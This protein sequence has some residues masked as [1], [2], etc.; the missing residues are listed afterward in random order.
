M[1]RLEGRFYVAYCRR[2]ILVALQSAWKDASTLRYKAAGR[3]LLRCVTKRLEGRF[4]VALQSAWKDAS[5]LR[6]KAA[7][8]T[9]LRCVTKRLEGRFY[10]ALQSGWKVASTLR[11]KAP[12]RSLL[13]CVTKRLGS[14]FY[15]NV[16]ATSLSRC[17]ANLLFGITSFAVASIHHT[18]FAALGRLRRR[19]VARVYCGQASAFIGILAFCP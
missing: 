5:T 19:T 2:D 16:D 1:K 18:F 12:G 8:R 14:R 6:Y 17:I 9:L 4:Y 13:R 7:G 10:V 3:T 11:Y 15:V